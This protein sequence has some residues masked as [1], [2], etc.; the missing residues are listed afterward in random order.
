MRRVL[1]YRQR[2][3]QVVKVKMEDVKCRRLLHH[4]LEVHYTVRQLIHALA[5]ETQGARTGGHQ[6]R[7]GD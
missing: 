3:V 5:V 1:P 4:L 2:K 6:T 7:L